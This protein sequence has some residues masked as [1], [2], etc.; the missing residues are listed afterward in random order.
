MHSV[1]EKKI[2]DGIVLLLMATMLP[3]QEPVFRLRDLDNQWQESAD[4]K[5]N[6]LTVVEM[7]HHIHAGTHSCNQDLWTVNRQ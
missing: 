2:V 4:L 3:A 6:H 1:I 7:V 5:G